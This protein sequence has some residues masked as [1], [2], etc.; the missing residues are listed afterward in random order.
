M[1]SIYDRIFINKDFKD[2]YMVKEKYDCGGY[3][4]ITLA[5]NKEFIMSFVTNDDFTVTNSRASIIGICK[6]HEDDLKNTLAI[7]TSSFIIQTDVSNVYFTLD[8]DIEDGA[9]IFIS[10]LPMKDTDYIS[11]KEIINK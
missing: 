4:E 9:V 6:A 10:K 2:N 7:I 3:F 1:M 11:I 8:T 5:E